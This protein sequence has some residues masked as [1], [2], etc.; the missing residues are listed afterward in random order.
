[1][2]LTYDQDSRLKALLPV[3]DEHGEWLGRVMRQIFYPETNQDPD[4]LVAPESFQSWIRDS[5]QDEILPQDMLDQLRRM[6]GDMAGMAAQLVYDSVSAQ[7]KP[8]IQKFDAFMV[9]YDE[10]IA[11]VRRIER[12][13]AMT[14]SGFDILTGL[15]SRQMLMKDL[16][17]EMER[18]SRRGRPFCLA[19]A[20]ID[21]YA[22][23][24]ANLPQSDY[25]A[26]IGAVGDIIKLCMRSFDDAYRLGSGEFLMCLK[27]ADMTGGT[28]GLGRLRK[29]LEEKAPYYT[30]N[31]QEMR[32]TMSSCVA[33]PQPGDNFDS[34]MANM[35]TDLD[36][37]GGN[38]ETAL[39]Y[40]ELSPL[41]RF[42]ST[43]D[44]ESK[45]SH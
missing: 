38:A 33:E 20:R 3:L 15:R 28:A 23:I 8:D 31:G 32:L 29:L 45:K 9:L 37:F 44:E 42:V 43:M 18:R 35:R 6:H 11:H 16:E 14:D 36:R 22:E 10:F 25:E 39:E 26:I 24:K 2:P 41:E 13:M 19:L 30:L 34:L 17:R 5:A 12:D 27:Q 21:H 1:M 40:L 7:Y 4:M